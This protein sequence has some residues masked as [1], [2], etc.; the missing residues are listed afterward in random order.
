MSSDTMM[1]ALG[2]RSFGKFDKLEMLEVPIPSIV[3]P[4]DILIKV[5]A[6]AL[7]GGDQVI[8]QGYSRVIETVKC[9]AL[10]ST[11]FTA[12]PPDCQ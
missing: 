12:N 4:D 9:F 10:F 5:K 8:I 11:Q 3:H 6:F 7:N 2:V 1:R